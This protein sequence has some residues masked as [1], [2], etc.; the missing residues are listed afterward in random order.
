VNAED[1][2]EHAHQFK[3][4]ILRTTLENPV[5]GYDS[6]TGYGFAMDNLNL[7]LCYVIQYISNQ[8]WF[9]LQCGYDIWLL[10]HSV[11]NFMIAIGTPP[12]R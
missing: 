7:T 5:Y 4:M 6:S 11:G 12:N 10:F 1:H 3:V 9:Y 8:C 2:V